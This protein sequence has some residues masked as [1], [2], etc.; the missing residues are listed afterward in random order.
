MCELIKVGDG[1]RVLVQPVS[2][3]VHD[4]LVEALLF[5]IPQNQC[6]TEGDGGVQDAQGGPFYHISDVILEFLCPF[7]L[8]QSNIKNRSNDG[9]NQVSFLSADPGMYFHFILELLNFD[10]FDEKEL[11]E[12]IQDLSYTITCDSLFKRNP[13]VSHSFKKIFDFSFYDHMNNSFCFF[14]TRPC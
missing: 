13:T 3:F 4:Q 9:S 5:I 14:F 7:L 6:L 10:S 8:V 11:E 12:V 2:Y 1:A